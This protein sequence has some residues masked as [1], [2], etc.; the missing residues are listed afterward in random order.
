[1]A[2]GHLG[3]RRERIP[4]G[5][6]RAGGQKDDYGVVLGISA[7]FRLCGVSSAVL[8]YRMLNTI[9]SSKK[10]PG[11]P[12][13]RFT[14]WVACHDLALATYRAT[15]SWPKFEVY[16]LTSQARRAAV[17]AVVNIAEGC[18][19]RGSREFRRYLDISLGSLSELSYLLLL[20]RDLEYT[21]AEKYG[22][23]E[24]LR[25]HA[26]RLTWGLYAAVA[27]RAGESKTPPAQSM[28]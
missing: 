20:S 13:E 15:E 8:L 23:I 11:K 1:M 7:K 19:K 4:W 14:A 25:D 16:G 24:A 12:Y 9:K 18:A 3:I 26:T 10:R 17:S 28:T 2:S 22:E 5:G 6:R 21:S 27:K